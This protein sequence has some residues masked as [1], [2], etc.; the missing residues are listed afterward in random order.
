LGLIKSIPISDADETGLR[1]SE[2]ESGLKKFHVKKTALIKNIQKKMGNLRVSPQRHGG[3][4]N[5][6]YVAR[7]TSPE[8]VVT[9]ERPIPANTLL[10]TVARSPSPNF[11]Q[12][13]LA[14]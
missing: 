12:E 11:M 5:Y 14:D 2:V 4:T 9:M 3:E 6:L 1:K 7:E 10:K 13:D 8:T